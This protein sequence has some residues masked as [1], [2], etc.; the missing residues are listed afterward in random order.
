MHS[1]FRVPWD[2]LGLT[3]NS[4][5]SADVEIK[6]DSAPSRQPLNEKDLLEQIEETSRVEECTDDV[7]ER[8]CVVFSLPYCEEGLTFIADWYDKSICAFYPQQ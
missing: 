5:F 1:S 7:T 4:S 3:M 2:T 6:D 8:R